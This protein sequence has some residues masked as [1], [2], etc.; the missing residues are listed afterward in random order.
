LFS[1]KG[2]IPL[3][4]YLALETIFKKGETSISLLHFIQ[5]PS[6][7][8]R[9][10]DPKVVI[11]ICSKLWKNCHPE[12]LGGNYVDF[13]ILLP[14]VDENRLSSGLRQFVQTANTMKILVSKVYG[15]Y[16]SGTFD[17]GELKNNL[18][19][20][21]R[22]AENLGTAVF[23]T[24]YL[25]YLEE[26]LGFDDLILRFDQVKKVINV[27][28]K[29]AIAYIK[30]VPDELK[31][32][33]KNYGTFCSAGNDNAFLIR[34]FDNKAANFDLAQ[35]GRKIHKL[36]SIN[37]DKPVTIGI[38]ASSQA[39]IG[40][41]K[42]P[43]AALWAFIHADL[44]GSGSLA[45][46]DSL[47]CNV[48]GDE[49]LCWGDLINACRNYRLGLKM[50]PL[51]TNLLNSLGVCLAELGRIKEA[52]D[53]LSRAINSYPENFMAF[54]NLGGIYYQ[55][56]DLQSAL[57]ILERAYKLKPD[58]IRLA[59]RMAEVLIETGHSKKAL[60]LL[61]PFMDNHS[62]L[63]GA[64]FRILGKAYKAVDRWQDAKRS[65]Q[66]A[67]KNNHQDAESMALLAL[68][69]LEETDNKEIA[70]RLGQQAG[71]FSNKS[72]KIHSILSQL[73]KKLNSFGIQE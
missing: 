62:P 65:W 29:Y 6:A 69:Y 10:G 46:Y 4:V 27:R 17:I 63:P 66:Q 15:H 55:Q 45:I 33:I 48:K 35:W 14:E 30:S 49:I 18:Y 54:Y 37:Q 8:A 44:L 70:K 1:K 73:N 11:E 71:K 38:A 42:A 61:A 19:G 67:I 72:K 22:L 53:T 24:I 3:Y 23:C 39:E 56:G 51:N 43:I 40:P 32:T 59:G 26:R 41:S 36:C 16:I 28:S 13:W 34:K 64:I 9:Y 50:D 25:K 68:G 47:T 5:K 2:Q 60:D 58:D 57:K 52:T 21:E 31:D 20:V 12:W 7:N